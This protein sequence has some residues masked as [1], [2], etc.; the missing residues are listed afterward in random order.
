MSADGN[1]SVEIDAG[2]FT[3]S[4]D[5]AAEE[6]VSEALAA[7]LSSLR[8]AAGDAWVGA[9]L[10]GPF[11]FGEAAMGYDADGHGTVS[12]PIEIVA[13]LSVP[14]HA[15]PSHAKKLASALSVTARS[16]KV[17]ATVRVLA[18]DLLPYL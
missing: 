5:P 12:E 7:C 6:R 10:A 14:P 3:L 16:R 11:A 1:A 13:V 8:D 18:R 17:E 4:R 9:A 15:V 2:A